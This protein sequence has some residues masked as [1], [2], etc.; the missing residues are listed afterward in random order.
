MLQQSP[1]PGPT[2]STRSKADEL[3]K[4]KK[5]DEAVA[6]YSTIW[7]DGDEWTGW[8]YAHSLRKLRRSPEALTVAEETHRIAP[9]F[10][11]GRSV[12]AW[13]AFDVIRS[14][15]ELTP[16]ELGLARRVVRLLEGEG[17]NHEKTSPFVPT[18]LRVARHLVRK[19]RYLQALTWLKKL[20]AA[21]LDTDE[22]QIQDERGKQRRLASHRE[23]YFSLGTA[24]FEKLERWKE[25]LGAAQSA[26]AAC[27]QLHH[28]NDIWLARRIARSKVNLGKVEEGL[29]E[30]ELLAKKKPASFIFTDIAVAAHKLGQPD[31]VES[32]C[33]DAL[34]A[35][36]DLG[37]KLEALLL[38]ARVLWSKGEHDRA[39]KHLA[40]YVAVRKTNA[41]RVDND[42]QTLAKQWNVVSYVDVATALSEL[43]PTW[44]RSLPLG[45]SRK[46]GIVDS[47]LPHGKA[48]FIVTRDKE[49]F[50]F[51]TR[52]LRNGRG[53]PSR[54]SRVTF[55]TRPSFDRK[56][57]RESVVAYDIRKD[58]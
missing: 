11:L 17:S 24:C 2:A 1:R 7:P 49:R 30:L 54:G 52:D 12:L 36:G 56:R 41:W 23:R 21:R 3:R 46:N 28:D 29:K 39:R 35:P 50:Y 51:E 19:R 9:N 47:I 10:A 26:V 20:D 45:S 18:V 5:F 40:L 55:A 15:E 32:A 57:N 58:H 13:A 44:R 31:R 48:G 16:N 4:Q 14:A 27:G 8:G 22:F 43:K 6:I 34:S 37:F 25:C 42:A 33:L 38:L 53:K